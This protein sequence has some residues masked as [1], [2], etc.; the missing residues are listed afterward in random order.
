M[1]EIRFVCLSDLHFGAENSIL[2]CLEGGD[3]VA[4]PATVSVALD[5]L[6]NALDPLLGS[7]EDRS[8]K[9]T[10]ILMATSSSWRW[11][12]TTWR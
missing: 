7:D 1:P 11:P 5:R 4:D 2:N 10:L 8:S 3:V 6:V 12:A 9:P